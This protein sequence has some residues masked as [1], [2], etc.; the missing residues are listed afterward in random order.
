M[1]AEFPLV[2]AAEITDPGSLRTALSV[3]RFD[4]AVIEN[5]LTW[6]NGLETIAR[7]RASSP[8]CPCIM[9]TGNGSEEIAVQA[10]K[11]GYDDYVQKS[12]GGLSR[13][14]ASARI[15]LD[16]AEERRRAKALDMRLENLLTRLNV[17]VCRARTDGAI[18][19]ANPA[20]R[21]L[22]ARTQAPAP[23]P[24]LHALF[25]DAEGTGAFASGDF[26]EGKPRMREFGIAMPNGGIRW[27]SVTASLAVPL[28]DTAD[29]WVGNAYPARAAGPID[30]VIELLVEDISERKRMDQRMRDQEETLRQFQNMESVGRLAGGMA[31][32]FNNLCTAINGYSELLLSTMEAGNPYRA[33]LEEIHRAGTRVARLTRDML[34]FSGRQML[35][36]GRLDLNRL[37]AGSAEEIRGVLGDDIRLDLDLHPDPLPIYCDGEQLKLAL[38]NLVTNAR[39]AMPA[40]GLLLIATATQRMDDRIPAPEREPAG[41]VRS[42]PSLRPGTYVVMTLADTGIGMDAAMQAHLFE[43]FFTAKPAMMRSGMGLAATYGIIKQ[44]GGGIGVESDPGQGTRFR[45]WLPRADA[46]ESLPPR[47][48]GFSAKRP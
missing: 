1:R 38:M 29:P 23:L 5:H 11:S 28:R 9:Y 37:L 32:D 25:P 21:R 6:S 44:S 35:Q 2:K 45:I 34:A 8:D 39:D 48:I 12:P 26:L 43:P 31:H 4:I 13:L 17:G 33:T 40:G 36:A 41:K 18:L 46:A 7:I 20:F 30:P 16:R 47:Q 14:C 24:T 10:L 15:A 27:L 42:G 3:F 19:Y 22:V